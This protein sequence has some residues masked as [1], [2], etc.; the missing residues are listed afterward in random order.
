MFS[1][2]TLED[3]HEYCICWL[4]KGVCR[5][6]SLR[7]YVKS[8]TL[9]SVACW[10]LLLVQTLPQHA[11]ITLAKQW[12]HGST[13]QEH[14]ITQ[15]VTRFQ[16]WK[17]LPAQV[18]HLHSMTWKAIAFSRFTKRTCKNFRISSGNLSFAK[19]Q[20]S[21]SFE[22]FL[23]EENQTTKDNQPDNQLTTKDQTYSAW[24][25]LDVGVT[26]CYHSGY[27]QCVHMHTTH[28]SFFSF[29]VSVFWMNIL[30]SASNVRQARRSVPLA[31]RV[32]VDVD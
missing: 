27:N 25:N 6:R 23:G 28:F 21:S 7:P 16:H 18:L 29:R 26:L 2:S 31:D 15:N 10:L 13:L 8:T 32:V 12:D 22:E 20:P 9:M 30:P 19:I 14:P 4:I 5:L 1:V 17:H 11:C 3:G 24:F